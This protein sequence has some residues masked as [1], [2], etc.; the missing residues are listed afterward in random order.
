MSQAP[1]MDAHFF[2]IQS[3]SI[4]KNNNN[5]TLSTAESSHFI[6]SLREIPL[7]DVSFMSFFSGSSSS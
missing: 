4:S 7:E 2:E 5:F 3:S 6:K 1:L